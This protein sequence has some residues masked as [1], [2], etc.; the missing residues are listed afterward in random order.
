MRAFAHTYIY[1]KTTTEKK[2]I[3]EM[4]HDD[5]Y[6]TF[7]EAQATSQ[8]QVLALQQEINDNAEAFARHQQQRLQE[9]AASFE[10][11]AYDPDFEMLSTMILIIRNR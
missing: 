10:V 5:E 1:T 8:R 11:H 7:Q 4:Q 9:A 6:Q 2:E 3:V